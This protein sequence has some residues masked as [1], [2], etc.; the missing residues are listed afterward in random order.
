VNG[1]VHATGRTFHLHGRRPEYF[2]MLLPEDVLHPGDNRLEIFAVG[3]RN[4]LRPL[5]RG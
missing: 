1:R 2:S 3:A 4:R 5:Y